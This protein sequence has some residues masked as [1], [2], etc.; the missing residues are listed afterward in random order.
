MATF[1]CAP[2]F[3]LKGATTIHQQAKP[4]PWDKSQGLKLKSP[5]GD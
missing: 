3:F 2:F 1:C 5:L 4:E